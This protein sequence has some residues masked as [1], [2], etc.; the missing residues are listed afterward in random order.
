MT[1][2]NNQILYVS[3]S[4]LGSNEANLVHVINQTSAFSTIANEVD[5]VC[6]S[7]LQNTEPKTWIKDSFGI[8]SNLPNLIICKTGWYGRQLSICFLALARILTKRYTHIVS[9]NLY[10]SF[11][12]S[13]F[14]IKHLY[15]AHSISLGWRSIIQ[16]RIF[17]QKKITITA[18][19]KGLKVDILAASRK[20]VEKTVY[21]IHDAATEFFP[22]D[23]KNYKT[24]NKRNIGYFGH[25]HK[26][27]G[28][29]TIIGLAKSFPNLI[30]N[31]YGGDDFL[32]ESFRDKNKAF[33]NLKF[34][35][36]V[37]YLQARREMLNQC[38][39]LLPYK[40]NIYLKDG[41]TDTAKWMSPLK[42]FEYL[43]S[44]KPIIASK[45][46]VFEEVLVHRETAM[47]CEANDLNDW[48]K[49]LQELLV[50]EILSE[51]LS[52]AGYLCWNKKYSWLSRAKF[53]LS[54]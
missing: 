33:V 47:L 31:V 6:A 5:L 13:F 30:F 37:P 49:V 29:D 51:K 43:A 17:N 15:E 54:L 24:A 44:R 3:P 22:I 28:I 38:I 4:E 48:Q 36:H 46:P 23:K 20:R 25:L 32:V 10:F 27:R 19:S 12:L 42:L 34:H 9:R 41:I 14:P 1:E 52:K 35:G 50:N 26:G 7:N 18:I 53:I 45:L 21:V 16:C 2:S 11:C 8:E 39:L 40:K